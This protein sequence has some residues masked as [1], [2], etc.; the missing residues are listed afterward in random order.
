MPETTKT[1]H[2]VPVPGA[3]KRKGE[4]IRTINIGKGIQALYDTNQKKIITYLFDKKQYTMKKAKE[5][6]K[7]NK[8]SAFH[9]QVVDIYDL[10]G[11]RRDTFNEAKEESVAEV[12]KLIEKKE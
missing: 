4:N 3:R 6:V 1:Y 9:Q 10:V 2:K 12:S 8:E 7:R 5:W 11:R